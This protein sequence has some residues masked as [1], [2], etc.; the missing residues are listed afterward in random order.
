[1]SFDAMTWTHGSC[2]FQDGIYVF[3]FVVAFQIDGC[4]KTTF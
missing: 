3:W 1:M 2:F 4:A